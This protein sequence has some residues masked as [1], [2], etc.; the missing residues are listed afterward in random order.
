MIGVKRFVPTGDP[1]TV[2]E[3]HEP[4]GDGLVLYAP[5]DDGAFE[6][7]N[8]VHAEFVERHQASDGFVREE[9]RPRQKPKAPDEVKP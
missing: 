4:A 9:A 5:D 8:P 7:A 3:V 6:V 1:V 2:L